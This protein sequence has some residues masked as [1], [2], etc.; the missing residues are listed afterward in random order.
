MAGACEFGNEFLGSTK[1]GEFLDRQAVSFSR[2][3]V[4][5]AVIIIVYSFLSK[6]FKY[7]NKRIR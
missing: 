5:R 2:R 3:T 1:C 7:Y 4:F 6:I